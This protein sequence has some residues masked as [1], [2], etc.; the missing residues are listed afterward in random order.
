MCRTTSTW[1]KP[2]QEFCLKWRL[3][4][5]KNTLHNCC[6]LFW[7]SWNAQLK[8]DF[9]W[10]QRFRIKVKV[11]WA[12]KLFWS[13]FVVS[14][15]LDLVGWNFFLGYNQ[16]DLSLIGKLQMALIDQLEFFFYCIPIRLKF[17]KKC[18]RE[19]AVLTLLRPKTQPFFLNKKDQMAN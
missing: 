18:Q 4:Q 5:N 2:Y 7:F 13:L 10:T 6:R 16:Y 1:T 19:E 12:S 3:K 15:F 14:F 9:L 8:N 17:Q 11:L